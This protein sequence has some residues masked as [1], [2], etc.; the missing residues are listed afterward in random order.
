MNQSK[1]SAERA[2]E[3]F[4]YDPATGS[5]TWRVNKGRA[6]AGAEAGYLEPNGYVRLVVDQRRYWA[7]RA[8]WLIAYG[9]LPAGCIDHANGNPSDNRLRNL[10]EVSH[11]VNMQNLRGAKR[12][13]STG[14]LGV[15]PH[16]GGFRACITTQGVRRSLGCFDTPEKA[17]QAYLTAKRQLHAGCMI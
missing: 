15:V 4:N 5:L 2:R 12:H 6:K 16:Q 14:F 11:S 7:H 10:R 9:Q 17:H 8:I 13:S 1:L 3:L